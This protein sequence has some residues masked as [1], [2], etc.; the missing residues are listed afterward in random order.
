MIRH[1]LLGVV[2]V[3]GA[4]GSAP[5]RADQTTDQAK[6]LLQQ[7]I[8]V[9]RDGQHNVLLRALRQLR[10]PGLEPL[11]SELVQRRFEEMK[12]HGVLGL[13]EIADPPRVDL[14][15]VAEIEEAG[16]QA[17]LVSAA[18]DSELL[19]L[20][21]ALQLANWPG[22]DPA[23]RVL[24]AGQLLA[25]GRKIDPGTLNE[26][27]QSDSKALRAMAAL[28]KAEAGDAEAMKVFDEVAAGTGL[29]ADAVRQVLL[30]TATRHEFDVI[31]PWATKL[32]QRDDLSAATTYQALRAALMFGAEGAAGQWMQRFEAAPS[33]A[34]KLRLAV[35][36]VDVADHVDPRLFEPVVQS[37][38][39]ELRQL[40]RVGQARARDED[41]GQLIAELVRMNNL[42]GTA[43]A[44]QHASRI[45][46]A[47]PE[48]ARP[49]L[50][51][52]VKASD[53]AYL[54]QPD[55]SDRKPRFARE[56]LDATVQATQLLHENDPQG[57]QLLRKLIADAPILTQEAM[58]MGLIRSDGKAPHRVIENTGPLASRTAEAMALLLRAKHDQPLTDDQRDQLSVIVRGGTGLRKPLRIQAAWVYLK[59]NQ[60]ARVTL[61]ELLSGG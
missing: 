9:H 38:G 21:D 47:K 28:L 43:W 14:A 39:P 40:G 19:P 54:E 60:Q 12:I 27:L 35:L 44:L 59:L 30:Q 57:P 20:E 6:W 34:E 56:R 55:G 37:E 24:V 8:L 42:L 49:I 48:Q 16:T 61:T 46:E 26:A 23:V 7:A 17:R 51:A 1:L 36:A 58:L 29:R 13:A 3:L 10:D 4:L 52:L 50:V 25:E 5:A 41:A 31:A 53:D 45:S 33:T 15:L 22:L 18:L 32:L 2:V 11:F